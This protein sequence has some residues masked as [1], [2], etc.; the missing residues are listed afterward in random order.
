MHGSLAALCLTSV[1]D[2][3]ID[4]PAAAVV[5][6]ISCVD[7]SRRQEA[8]RLGRLLRPKTKRSAAESANT[9]DAFF[10]TLTSADTAETRHA[11][12]RQQWV[13]DQGYTYQLLDSETLE[14][15][16]ARLGIV[17]ATERRICGT[18]KAE[19]T[20]LEHIMKSLPRIDRDEQAEKLQLTRQLS[21][22]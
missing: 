18:A 8:Q 15:R 5:V 9:A 10:Y 22:E 11:L 20:L 17:D 4:L 19:A 1:G 7:G 6:Q 2:V 13:V 16:V 21:D 3:A 12:K 14:A